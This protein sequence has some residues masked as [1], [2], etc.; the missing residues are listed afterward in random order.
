MAVDAHTNEVVVGRI[1]DAFGVKGQ[2]KVRSF[3]EQ[4]E[5]LLQYRDWLVSGT[6]GL[7]HH[8]RVSHARFDG[9]FVI[10]TLSGLNDRD[11]ALELKGADVR[12]ERSALP[13]LDEGEFYWSD[14]IGMRV[15]GVNDQRFGVL[16]RIMETG[17][18]DVLVVRGEKEHLIPYVDQVVLEV[19]IG[20]R[21]IRVDWD[22]E[23]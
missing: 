17:A 19:D 3:T 11:Q 4:P 9:R 8:H 13:S 22:A 15:I 5:S 14:L 6:D 12:I 16:S 21:A 7:P 18:N 23:F 20:N 1:A 10:A 2:V